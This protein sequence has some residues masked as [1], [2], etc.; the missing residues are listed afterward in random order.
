MRTPSSSELLD[1]W[2]AAST[3]GPAAR[4]LSLLQAG[5]PSEGMA[6][7]ARLPVGRR[8]GRLLELRGSVFG[9]TLCAAV[10]CP[11]CGERLELET[12]AEDL[13]GGGGAS[14]AV[15]VETVS[16]DGWVVRFR[17]PNSLDMTAV[18]GRRDTDAIE[19]ALLE[20][21]VLEAAFDGRS[22]A[23]S[24]LPAEVGLAVGRR[25]A[26]LD[27]L[28]AAVIEVDCPECAHC[29]MAPVNVAGFVWT[30][31]DAWARRTLRQVHELASAYSWTEA[32]VLALSPAKRARYL[33][34]V[35][36]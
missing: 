21:C 5:D 11:G 12:R 19:R 13:P 20:R 35:A 26:E 27:P 2:A 4:S 23:A 9:P 33:E 15:T 24:E 25:M 10:T 3:L 8:D 18:E 7:L 17:L 32:T 28:A 6:S 30:E 34:L 1:A 36:G 29:W 22:V 14:D 16:A 31:V